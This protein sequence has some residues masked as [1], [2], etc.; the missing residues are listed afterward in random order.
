METWEQDPVIRAAL[1]LIADLPAP[2]NKSVV[3]YLGLFRPA[4][5]A[6]GWKRVKTL[7]TEINDITTK[8]YVHVHGKADKACSPAIYAKAMEQMTQM[9]SLKRPMKGHNYLC[10][11]AWDL[12][13]AWA[14]EQE[15]GTRRAEAAHIPTRDSSEPMSVATIDPLAKLKENWDA[16]K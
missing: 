6:L 2:V 4:S 10:Q 11:V 1:V 7:L 5:R 8:G 9:T 14:R 16:T 3:S 15:A 13:E 12:A